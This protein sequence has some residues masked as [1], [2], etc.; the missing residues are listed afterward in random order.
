MI[1]YQWREES[2]ES[3]GKVKRPIARV[4]IKDK[5]GNWRAITMLVDSGADIS[6]MTRGYGE[7]FG[8][9]VERGRKIKLRGIGQDEIVAYI[10]KMGM[11]IGE[12]EFSLEVAIAHID[13]K[14]SVLGRR[15]LFDLFE[16]QFKNKKQ[17]TWF[18]KK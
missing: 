16:I 9:N 1:E 12:H 5:N 15:N 17:Q 2:S 18:L 13:L 6:I 8:H 10:H 11:L 3:F 7:L 4:H 14:I